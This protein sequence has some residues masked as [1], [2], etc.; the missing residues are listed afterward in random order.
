MKQSLLKVSLFV[1]VFFCVKST[2]AFE[3][4]DKGTNKL[5]LDNAVS[6]IKAKLKAACV[7]RV[8]HEGKGQSPELFYSLEDEDSVQLLNDAGYFNTLLS[9]DEKCADPTQGGTLHFFVVGEFTSKPDVAKRIENAKG[10]K[11]V[12]AMFLTAAK[13]SVAHEGVNKTV[14]A[15]QNASY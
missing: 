14:N 15:L 3:V 7:M 5:E 2:M 13:P 8:D 12:E 1:P 9:A 11:E 10:F 4:V 6:Y